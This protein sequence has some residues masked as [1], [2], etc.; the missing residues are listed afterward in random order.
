MAN[1]EK[2]PCEGR[3]YMFPPSVDDWLSKDDIVDFVKLVVNKM[4]MAN[5]RAASFKPGRGRARF[6]FRMMLTVV[7]YAY[8][9]GI[10]T[11]REM[12]R[13][14][15][16]DIGFR[17]IVGELQPDHTSFARFLQSLEGADMEILFLRVLIVCK[18]AGMKN[19]GHVSLDGTKV[20]ANA[21]LAS[22]RDADQLR[23]RVQEVLEEVKEAEKNEGKLVVQVKKQQSRSL[24]SKY[25]TLARLEAALEDLEREEREE[26]LARQRVI[27]KRE[28]EERETG[29]RKRGRKPKSPGDAVRKKK[30]SMVD[31]ESR[32]MKTIIGYVQGFNAQF[33]VTLDQYI[34]AVNVTN[35]A[36]D[37]RQLVPMSLEILRNLEIIENGPLSPVTI[38]A[39]SG[40]WSEDNMSI[41]GD[42]VFLLIPPPNERSPSSGK[43]LTSAKLARQRMR[44][45]L[46]SP[47]GRKSYRNRSITVEPVI[48]QLKCTQ[49]ARQVGGR[50]LERCRMEMR[51]HATA[52]NIKKLFRSAPGFAVR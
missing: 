28:V 19:L 43:P 18:K 10:R 35:D 11:T 40:Y 47:E 6:S 37:V 1:V 9:Q 33:A 4:D 23:K 20:S 25:R 3:S 22:N 8:C 41:D 16:R 46:D 14:C 52:H 2:A 5:V 24:E 36:N 12:E 39:D 15:Q 48:G 30:R 49:G 38:A 34:I 45:K 32:V 44:L 26:M 51:L 13:A 17:K 31:P 7:I 29:R 27:E 21:S 42:G 50:G